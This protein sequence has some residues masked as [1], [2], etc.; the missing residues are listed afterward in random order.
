[1]ANIKKEQF[2]TL[3]GGSKINYGAPVVVGNGNDGAYSVIASQIAWGDSTF[4][5][6]SYQ[7]NGALLKVENQTFGGTTENLITHVENN[8]DAL[9]K[10]ISAVATQGIDSTAVE[11]IIDQYLQNTDLTVDISEEPAVYLEQGTGYYI[12]DINIT[13]I[14][15]NDYK[16]TYTFA[17]FA[18]PTAQDYWTEFTPTQPPAEV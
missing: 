13:H 3:L 7:S 14:D 10:R 9:N 12:T 17:Y 1:M 6:Y 18:Q 15:G 4:T 11:G 2:N 8:F 5:Q 16:Y